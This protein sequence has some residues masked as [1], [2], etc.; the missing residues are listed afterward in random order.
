MAGKVGT[1]DIR[2]PRDQ[3]KEGQEA[4]SNIR[5][6]L[7]AL[8]SAHKTLLAN[9][10]QAIFAL[11]S[12]TSSSSTSSTTTTTGTTV[13]AHGAIV[14]GNDGDPGE[15]G[16]P[17][18]GPPGAAGAAG[19]TGAQGPL[20]PAAYFCMDLT[21][22]IDIGNEALSAAAGSYPDPD[23]GVVSTAGGLT[24][25]TTINDTATYTTGGIT[26]ANQIALAGSA[27]RVRAHGTFVAVSSATTR[28][29]QVAVFWG[30]T[31]LVAITAAVLVSTAQTTTWEL[32]FILAGSSTT[33]IWTTGFLNNNV[34]S[35]AALVQTNATPASTTVTAGAQTLDLRFSMSVAVATDQWVVQQVTMERIK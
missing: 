19:S 11:Q 25:S 29:A 13:S 33:A 14:P 12:A 5:A 26:L 2:V 30:S 20:G 24:A 3:S 17:V 18:P 1:P 8:E 23:A 35:A 21:P 34:A 27:W 16:F 31:Q 28:N 10:Q 4:V 6:R 9:T 15:D 22:E 32:E 7:I